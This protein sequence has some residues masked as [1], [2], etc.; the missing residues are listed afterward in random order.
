MHPLN[1]ELCPLNELIARFF[2]TR[3]NEDV[4]FDQAGNTAIFAI[5][6]DRQGLYVQNDLPVS[7]ISF[8]DCLKGILHKQGLDIGKDSNLEVYLLQLLQFFRRELLFERIQNTAY[9]RYFVHG[10]FFPCSRSESFQ[11]FDVFSG[12]LQDGFI[13]CEMQ[14]FIG[15]VPHIL[16]LFLIR[17]VFFFAQVPGRFEII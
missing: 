2:A 15:L 4:V 8:F 17:A 16:K 3:A 11:G 6:L 12:F 10:L 14:N 7:A 9:E 1:E 5:N 13:F